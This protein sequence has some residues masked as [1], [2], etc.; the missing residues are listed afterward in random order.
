MLAASTMTE[1]PRQILT[2]PYLSRAL[3]IGQRPGP[4]IDGLKS[5]TSLLRQRS[6]MLISRNLGL[7][8]R[9]Q[10]LRIDLVG[11]FAI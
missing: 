11:C 3:I 7:I 9:W 2:Q 5:L 6:E 10:G 1:E 4:Q 8:V